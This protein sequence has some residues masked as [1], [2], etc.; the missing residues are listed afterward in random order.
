MAPQPHFCEVMQGDKMAF[1]E[2]FLQIG[3][4]VLGMTQVLTGTCSELAGNEHVGQSIELFLT[5]K[6]VL[7]ALQDS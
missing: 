2:G 7:A 5:T 3:E 6:V 1:L 4:L